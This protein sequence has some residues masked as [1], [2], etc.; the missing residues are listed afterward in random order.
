MRILTDLMEASLSTLSTLSA[1]RQH[2]LLSRRHLHHEDSPAYIGMGAI[3]HG[4]QRINNGNQPPFE[5]IPDVTKWPKADQDELINGASMGATRHKL[6]AD[7]LKNPQ[8]YMI[9][10]IGPYN[11]YVTLPANQ[12]NAPLMGLAIGDKA[13][14]ATRGLD[15]EDFYDY[16]AYV[17]HSSWHGAKAT[18]LKGRATRAKNKANE[19]IKKQAAAGMTGTTSFKPTSNPPTVV[20][21]SPRNQGVANP[22]YS[23]TN[24]WRGDPAQTPWVKNGNK[25]CYDTI[26]LA[27]HELGY[28]LVDMQHSDMT[29]WKDD[30]YFSTTAD[31]KTVKIYYDP[32]TSSGFLISFGEYKAYRVRRIY[33]AFDYNMTKSN[34]KYYIDEAKQAGKIV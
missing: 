10:S 33:N 31:G 28:D 6:L 5:I 32:T 2:E 19:D 22:Y 15:D 34:L 18:S 17:K 13:V 30:Y 27:L 4:H 1:Q 3:A 23:G 24:Q 29:R 20:D 11:N 9:K 16:A 8:N 7:V 25:K 12:K 14:M 26:R 21:I